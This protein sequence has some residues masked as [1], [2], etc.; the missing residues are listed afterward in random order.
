MIHFTFYQK[1]P[2]SHY[3]YIDMLIDG[4]TTPS[5]QLQLPA[6]RPGRYEL[7]NFAKN[8]KRLDAF[9]A[10]GQCL[11]YQKLS[12]DLWEIQCAGEEKI[13]V[14]YSYYAAELNAGAC[15]ADEKQVYVNPVHT[16]F[17]IPGRENEAQQVHVK[18]PNDYKIASSLQQKDCVLYANDFEELVDSPFMA[19]A[20]VQS[21]VY[22]VEGINFYLHFLGDCKPNWDKIK[23][24]FSAFTQ[25]QVKFWGDFP[26]NEYHFLFQVLP[27]KF[28]HGVEHKKSTVI[29]IGPGYHLNEGETYESVLGVCCHELFHVW[30]IKTI[31]PAEMLPYNYTKENYARTGYVYEGF[32]TYYGDK[33]LLSSDV[34]NEA[35]YFLTLQERLQKHFHNFG[36]FNLS[37]TA[38]SWDTWLDGYVPGAPYRKTNIYDEGNLIALML[39]TKIL[40]ATNNQKSLRDVCVLL[41]TRYGKQNKGYTESDIIAVVSEVM[42]QAAD[43]FFKEMVYEA[44]DYETGISQTFE[45]LGW[46]LVKQASVHVNENVFG[47]K[48]IDN[49]GFAKVSLV[50]PYSP[51]WQ[52]GLFQGDD[53]LAVNKHVLRNNL[54]HWLNYHAA[55]E[56]IR[57]TV[58]K[59]DT[60]HEIVLKKDPKGRTFF[61]NPLVKINEK[62]SESQI[63]NYI[64]WKTNQL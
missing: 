19:S 22:Q 6:W 32:T 7:G 52:A 45:Y 64:A 4:I 3:I 62:Q 25:Y 38:S 30:N 12:K 43:A 63:Q 61:F 20:N 26:Y 8:I 34:F 24:D 37:V 28:Y 54:Q 50:A 39:D 17:Y 27:V 15:F 5:I 35:D 42:G 33:L 13:K 2:A 14:T 18:V 53:I 56:S 10:D 46:H 49:N 47:F 55:D 9:S 44:V 31:R 59:A 60:L 57:L 23:K 51:A 16:C 41:Y 11:A 58:N 40:Q 21:D 1:N 29:A 36:R 48:A